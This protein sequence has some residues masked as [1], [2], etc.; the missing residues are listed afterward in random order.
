M[1]SCLIHNRYPWIECQLPIRPSDPKGFCILH[2]QDKDKD[3]AAFDA[4]LKEKLAREDYDFRAVFFPGPVFFA[5]HEFKGR[6]DFSGATFFGGAY[7]SG[8]TFSERAYFSGATFSGGAVFFGA[9]FSKEADFSE[10]IFSGLA[11]FSDA[12][13][14]GRAIFSYVN[15]PGK[16]GPRLSF[17][18]DF[19]DLRFQ[20]QGLLRFQDL[21]LAQ[22]KFSGTDLRRLEF[23]NV[24]WHRHR[25]RDQ[26]YD[27]VLLK[28]IEP[29]PSADDYA[30][31]EE[32]YRYLKLNYEGAGDH[33]KA[34]DFHYGEM[35]MHR[36]TSAGR[37]WASW[38]SIYWAL[39][40]YGERPVRALICLAGLILGLAG[41]VFWLEP[42]IAG[43]WAGL[44]EALFYLLAQA[45]F[46][47]PD[48]FKPETNWG[49]FIRII[50]PL[51]IPGQAALLL[52]A[53]RN[54]LGR[55]R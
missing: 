54:R 55:R 38:Y 48:W 12:T 13:I 27:E 17:W 3:Q 31:V 41:L 10:A 35:E 20:D 34:G 25:G 16:T 14:A 1:A 5:D 50:S 29:K 28:V 45:T 51:L 23:H 44:R 9:R 2:S 24:T 4:A 52:L 40:G 36:R 7:F 42:K 30:R 49:K 21:S 53:L 32:L 46:Q 37:R 6:A 15:P 11:G 47:R 43:G 33:K 22:V 8:A 18:G 19:W 26:V 39:S